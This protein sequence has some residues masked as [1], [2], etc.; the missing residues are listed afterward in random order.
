MRVKSIVFEIERT[1]DV[2]TAE[3]IDVQLALTFS[4]GDKRCIKV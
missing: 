4:E 3:M 2:A 1:K